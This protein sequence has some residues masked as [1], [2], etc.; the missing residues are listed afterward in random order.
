[1]KIH[2]NSIF[3]T[4]PICEKMFQANLLKDDHDHNTGLSRDR[5][6]NNCNLMLG[7]AMDSAEVLDNASKYIRYWARRHARYD[8]RAILNKIRK[9]A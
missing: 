9:I 5:I 1:M 2:A 6:C 7:Q 3:I 4:C 8:L